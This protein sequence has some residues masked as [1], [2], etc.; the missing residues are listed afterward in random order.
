[1]VNR[2][3][4][5]VT[6]DLKAEEGKALLRR[7]A[8]HSDVM[9]ENY[10]PGVLDKLGIGPKLLASEVPGLVCISMGA[11]G[12]RGPWRGFRAYGSTVEQASGLPFVNGEAAD[13]PTM[14]HVAYGDPIAGLYGAIA[15][16]IALYGQRKVRASAL[17]DL[18]QVEC[19]F[20]LCADAIIAQS[21][22]TE[23][24]ARDGSRHPLSALRVVCGTDAPARW[25]AVSV[26]TPA[27]WN[28]LAGLL[29]RPDL[30]VACDAGVAAM[31]RHERVMEGALREWTT[32]RAASDA[33]DALQAAGV[34]AGP[35]HAAQDLL[36]DPQLA[37]FWRR[38]DRK[39]IGSHVV[40]HAPYRLDDRR[41]PL[42]GASP[43]LGEH[44]DDVLAGD[45]RLSR[46]E[47]DGLALRN[48]IGTKAIKESALG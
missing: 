20:Q 2:N 30:S 39:F 43:T 19:L 9:I 14:Q 17:I 33:V 24:L 38:V 37:G 10:A 36:T 12:A 42:W 13:P 8:A 23:L 11:F 15:C 45:L 46:D 6:L 41:P 18:G 22:Q 28:A 21:M 32:V 34:P 16:L 26:E 44:N 35:I 3:K 40:P 29:A 7:L 5:G 4:R 1:M 25:I 47:I 27:Q 48:I 31:K